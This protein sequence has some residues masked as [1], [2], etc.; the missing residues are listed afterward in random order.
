MTIIVKL[1]LSKMDILLPKVIKSITKGLEKIG[2]N[3]ERDGRIFAPRDTGLLK[4]SIRSV[5]KNLKVLI[6]SPL[7]YADYMEEPGNVRQEGQRP[8]MHPALLKNIPTM[9]TIVANAI[10]KVTR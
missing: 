3:V 10:K 2:R 5:Q 6:R 9:A 7:K 1:D 8:Y 4:A